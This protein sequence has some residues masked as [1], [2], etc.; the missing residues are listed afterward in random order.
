VVDLAKSE[1]LRRRVIK[2]KMKSK[3]ADRRK[4]W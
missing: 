3:K 1:A 2:E 4:D